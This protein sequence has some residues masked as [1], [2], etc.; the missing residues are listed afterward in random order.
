MNAPLSIRIYKRL[1]NRH[2]FLYQSL[3]SLKLSRSQRHKSMTLTTHKAL[4]IHIKI[5]TV[6]L[7]SFNEVAI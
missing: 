3:S 6:I 2:Y 5:S 4:L 7:R 1:I